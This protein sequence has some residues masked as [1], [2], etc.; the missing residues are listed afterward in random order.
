MN[1]HLYTGK[2]MT[3]LEEQVFS[4]RRKNQE[5]A[6]I[7]FGGKALALVFFILLA[8]A[9]LYFT[10]HIGGNGYGRATADAHEWMESD[11]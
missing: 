1:Y 9:Q 6:R 5:N 11:R 3:E 2:P 7:E 4:Q 8:L 10:G